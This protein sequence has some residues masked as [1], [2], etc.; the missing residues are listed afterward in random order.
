MR[1]Q[2]FVVVLAHSL[3]GRLRRIQIPHKYL[4]ALVG[5]VLFSS[6]ATFGMISSYLRMTLKV[7][8]YNSLRQEVGV[9]RERYEA[10][11]RE[12]DEKDH[13]LASLQI[14]AN[15]VSVAYGIKRSLEGPSD[16]S[17]E[18]ALLPTYS[19]SLDQYNFLRSANYS[20][21]QRT[22]PRQWQGHVQP[23]LW[24]VQGR[25]MS[26]FG[27]RSDP[28]SGE[29]AVHKGIDLTAP[30]GTPVAATGDGIVVHAEPSGRYG[31]L[32]IID[33]GHGMQTWY[34]HLSA[35][36]VIAGQEIRRGDT[37]GLS[38]G[39]GRVTSPHLHYEVRENGN[40]VNP[41]HF[42]RGVS[43]SMTAR[44]DLPF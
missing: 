38:G 32:V 29:D 11:R 37:L 42:L 27:T 20:M 33:H 26:S 5:L 8:N 35:M 16:I 34:A 17:S 3:H 9:L 10:L 44:H 15:E 7:S 25:I 18:G 21:I 12:A 28:F 14:L 22:Y 13:Q 23:S 24:P 31:K 2:Y 4:Y 6:V 1:Q 30:S 40:P 39:T 36:D 43:V 19:Q 41:A